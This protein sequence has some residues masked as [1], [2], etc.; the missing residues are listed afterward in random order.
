MAAFWL[1]DLLVQRNKAVLVNYLPT[2]GGQY[3]TFVGCYEGFIL[4]EFCLLPSPG[5]YL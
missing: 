1:I 5:T 2:L 3:R 4:A